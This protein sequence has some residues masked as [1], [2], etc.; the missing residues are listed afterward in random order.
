MTKILV[1][2]D[3]DKVRE[4]LFQ[5]LELEG[6]DVL[7]AEDGERGL[8]MMSDLLPDIVFCDIMMVDTDGYE[9][10]RRKFED[11]TMKSIR[12]GFL[13][14]RAS[15]EEI[16]QGLAAGA[17]FFLTKPFTRGQLLGLITSMQ[18]EG[19]HTTGTQLRIHG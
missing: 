17:D 1:I 8:A 9:V 13:S 18:P 19:V 15:R 6:F 3:N 2:E 7:A 4:S 10:L 14:A 11:P 5:I 12:F 16:E